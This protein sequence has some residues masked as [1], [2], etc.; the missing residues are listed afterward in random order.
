MLVVSQLAPLAAKEE[1]G[2]KLDFGADLYLK[3]NSEDVLADF[4][5][6]G[7]KLRFY[8]YPTKNWE[9]KLKI[10]ADMR[11]FKLEELY[12]DYSFDNSHIRFGMYEN[13]LVYEDG[14]KAVESPF[15]LS[16][17]INNRLSEMGWY[18]DAGLGV[19]YGYDIGDSNWGGESSAY[20]SSTTSTFMFDSNINYAMGKTDLGAIASVIYFVHPHDPE[21]FY[22]YFNAYAANGDVKE[23]WNYKWDVSFG[24]NIGDPG[25]NTHYPGGAK[26]WSH[27]WASDAYLSYNVPF[28]KNGRN[29]WTPSVGATYT[30]HDIE[31]PESS[32]TDVKLGSRFALRKSFY[33][34]TDAGIRTNIYYDPDLTTGLELLWAASLRYRY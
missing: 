25:G 33:I 17:F 18:S 20:F 28:G 4:Y 31:V 12:A 1:I 22:Y 3:S 13:T 5:D 9:M 10:Q 27:F 2:K 15:V 30:M 29:T 11:K 14:L 6:I 26:T 32:T 16:S 19:T 24:K 23:K 21:S 7:A 8:F 34:H